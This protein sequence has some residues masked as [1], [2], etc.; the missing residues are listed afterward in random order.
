VFNSDS[1]PGAS[2]LSDNSS[3]VDMLPQMPGTPDPGREAGHELSGGGGGAEGRSLDAG[4]GGL[5]EIVV[6]QRDR[7]RQRVMALEVEKGK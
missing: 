4:A 7:F 5:L 6:S 2:L 1:G 3:T